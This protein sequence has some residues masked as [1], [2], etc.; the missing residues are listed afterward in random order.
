MWTTNKE[1]THIHEFKVDGTIQGFI[2][3]K[4]DSYEYTVNGQT[5]SLS[6]F[7]K[8][9]DIKAYVERIYAKRY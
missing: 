7:E 9:H 1:N 4:R 3:V 6:G 2:T 8:L 5:K